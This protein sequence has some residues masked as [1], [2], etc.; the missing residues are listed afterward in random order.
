[1]H[2]KQAIAAI[3]TSSMVNPNLCLHIIPYTELIGGTPVICACPPLF[4]RP[5]EHIGPLCAEFEEV[6]EREGWTKEAL[7]V[8]FV[9]CRLGCHT[10]MD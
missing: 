6:I 4:G 3:H 5:T 7:D 2:K 1:M 10:D 9:L 8:L